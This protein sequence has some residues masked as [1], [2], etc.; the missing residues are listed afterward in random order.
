MYQGLA[1]VFGIGGLV[2]IIGGFISHHLILYPF[3]GPFKQG[4]PWDMCRQYIAEAVKATG[5]SR[6]HAI[7]P[8]GD[9]ADLWLSAPFDYVNGDP[10]HPNIKGDTKIAARMYNIIKPVLGW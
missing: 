4:K 3:L 10:Y 6:A 9:G 7:D 2:W 1:A 8:V 5:D